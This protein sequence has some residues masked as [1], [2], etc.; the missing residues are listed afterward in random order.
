LPNMPACHIAIALDARG[1]N[2]SIT[3][4]EVSSLLALGEAVR[5]I[6]RGQ[7]DVIITGGGGSRVNPLFWTIVDNSVASRRFQEPERASRPFDADRDGMVYGEGAA[8][9]IVESRQHAEARGAKILARVLG[10]S[11]TFERRGRDR[12]TTGAGTVAAIRGALRDAHMEPSQVGHVNAHGLSTAA[13]DRM[14]AQAIQETV[15][16]IPV[17]APKS[18]FG[19]LGGGTGAVEMAASVLALESGIVPATLNF[20]QADPL[21]PIEV[22][23]GQPAAIDRRTALLLNQAP[24]GQSVAVVLAGGE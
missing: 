23:K 7:A 17:T 18:F 16:D 14:E 9:F 13:E 2:N 15:G 20:E 3:M 19:N 11:S 10:F 5:T 1:P 4:A 21:C 24:M 22:L 12:S 8:A 6:E